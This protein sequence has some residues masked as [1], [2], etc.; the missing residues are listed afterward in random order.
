[1][2]NLLNKSINCIHILNFYLGVGQSRIRHKYLL[3]Y[4]DYSIYIF[5]MYLRSNYRRIIPMAHIL[6]TFFKNYSINNK[7]A[8]NY[9][10]HINNSNMCNHFHL[11]NCNKR[12]ISNYSHSNYTYISYFHIN[13]VDIYCSN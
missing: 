4:H 3:L 9:Y 10:K 1:M 12:F 2:H 7:I 6:H 8:T 11:K 13:F 5:L